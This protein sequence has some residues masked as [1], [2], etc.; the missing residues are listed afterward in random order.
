[1]RALLEDTLSILAEDL[2]L[3]PGD[4]FPLKS[5]TRDGL[6]YEMMVGPDGYAIHLGEG[7]EAEH[8][9]AECWHTRVGRLLL[10]TALARYEAQ[11][12]PVA[13][14][15]SDEQ[16]AVIKNTIAKGASNTELELF[17]ATCRRTGLDPFLKQIYAIQRRSQVN[18][19]W[20]TTMT[21]QVG[22]DGLRLVADRTG[23][24]AG[25]DPIEWLDA[26][27]VWSSV[28]TGVGDHPIAART[29]VY[30]KDFARPVPA[31]ARWDSYVQTT[32]QGKPTSMWERMPDVMLG[33]CAESLA[34]RRAFPAEMSGLAAAI[35]SEYD[36]AAEVA[37]LQQASPEIVEGLLD[38]P[39]P[40][41]D[42]EIQAINRLWGRANESRRR[43]VRERYPKAYPSTN[44][45]GAMNRPQ[46]LTAD[47]AQDV[48]MVLNGA[49]QETDV[50]ATDATAPP[51]AAATSPASPTPECEHEWAFNEDTTLMVCSKCGVIQEEPAPSEQGALQV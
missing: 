15:F 23:K 33:K 9:G 6:S 25:M 26:D 45:P 20:V 19:Q 40:P 11:V 13:I 5:K 36:P 43:T 22:I 31:V 42:E 39:L 27:G 48:M 47:E 17:V 29:N 49:A 14:D 3:Q 8:F 2:D 35:D 7:C 1:M 34:L 21:I 12:S 32:G 50:P 30:R 4:V 16:L 51:R 44:E 37:E 46:L 10:T 38:A 24:Y 28:W 18:G 41:S